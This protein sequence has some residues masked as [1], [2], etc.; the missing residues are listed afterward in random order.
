M[1]ASVLHE[2]RRL[3]AAESETLGAARERAAPEAG[4][5]PEVGALLA[6]LARGCQA[7]TAVEVGAASGL[8]GLWLL[9]ALTGRRV[10]TSIEPDPY[11]H[12]LATDAF[13]AADLS[14]HV[15]SIRGDAD[16]VLARLSDG[17]Y[18]L[19]LLQGDPVRGVDHLTHAARLLRPDGV[20]VVRGV[21]RPGE[22]AD[23]SAALLGE[24]LEAEAFET[25]VLP[26]DDG[27]AIGRRRTAEEQP[28]D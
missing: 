6:W 10:L 27:L 3:T 24:L 14:D 1:D 21:A 23:A 25:V 8:T 17:A 5:P 26:L 7:A 2:L 4:V 9:S 15:R 12:G 22:H 11:L 28:P 19:V 13:A 18:D 16:T 20:L